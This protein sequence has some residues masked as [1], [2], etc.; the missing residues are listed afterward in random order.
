MHPPTAGVC[1]AAAFGDDDADKGVI[2]TGL[3]VSF[4]GSSGKVLPCAVFCLHDDSP[5]VDSD[6]GDIPTVVDTPFDSPVD[7]VVVQRCG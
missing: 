6:S 4:G 7:P 2:V 1:C 5:S 3:G